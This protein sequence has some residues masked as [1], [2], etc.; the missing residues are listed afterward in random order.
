MSNMR[1]IFNSKTFLSF[2]LVM[3]LAIASATAAFAATG[4]AAATAQV[5]IKLKLGSG[6]MTVDGVASAVQPPFQK[7]GV[8]FI[9]LSV[10]TKGI[11]AQL[12]LAGN[13]KMT[14]THSASLKVVIA[15]GSK[16]AYVNGVQKSLPAAPVAV[17]GFMMVPLR[18][19]ELFGAKIAFTAS[20]K[21]IVIKGPKAAAAGGKAGIDADAG[22]SKIGDS[23]F[24]WSMNYPTGLA[25]NYQSGTG[26]FISFQDVKKDYYLSV[27]V[28][29]A[30]EPLD[31]KAQLDELKSYMEDETVINVKEVTLPSG[32]LQTMVTK[33]SDG[34][35]YEYRG[36]Q[37]NDRFYIL[38]FG[39]KAKA[40]S[41]LAANAALLNS[42]AP[43]FDAKN[44]ALKDLSKVKDGVVT[45]TEEDYGLAI[46]L[47]PEWDNGYDDDGEIS[48]YNDDASITF[49]ITSL[50]SGDTL[51][52]W[53]ERQKAAI[54]E[55][56]ADKYKEPFVTTDI[57]WNGIPAKMVKLSFTQDGKSWIE[58][59]RIFAIKGAYKYDTD[60]NFERGESEL[61]A[62]DILD[63]LQNNMKV[64]FARVEK[65]FGQVPDP[66]DDIDQ[67]K[68]VV[69]T[70]KK[71][72]YSI[73]VPED[74]TYNGMNMDQEVVTFNGVG[75][76]LLVGF[77]KGTAMQGYPEMMEK[78]YTSGGLWK[79][80]SRTNETLAGEAAVKMVLVP[81]LT[82]SGGGRIT[83][84]LIEKNDSIYMIQAA[85]SDSNATE[86]NLKQIDDAFKSFKFNS[87]IRV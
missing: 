82:S 60:L 4:T 81:N 27:S 20:T 68:T 80:E 16:T 10:L 70:S 41:E 46:Q 32:K 33:A 85:M 19:A 59:Y 40:A 39:K 74:W 26:D 2:L 72:G 52:A 62:A 28:E 53:V 15:T 24:Q 79:L 3:A 66:E 83:L 65:T 21:E 57:V 77:E 13:K 1:I 44:G 61:N 54:D 76:N 31:A 9:P 45:Y 78:S 17:K 30:E 43:Q 35:Y 69:K 49:D 36:I 86:F 64:D 48:Y 73:T 14:L 50:K 38:M 18:V 25:Q 37:A 5:V 84:Y 23:Y 56:I 42:F 47:P 58:D 71:N 34:F 87:G 67:H 29:D 51:D 75:L 55:V 11:G 63:K 8:T 6:Q 22:K 12:Q 7:G